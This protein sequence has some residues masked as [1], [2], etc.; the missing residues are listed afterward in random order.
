[1]PKHE[2]RAR[3]CLREIEKI[4]HKYKLTLGAGD[5]IIMELK[6]EQSGSD[7]RLPD[8]IAYTR[9][10]TTPSIMLPRGD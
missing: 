8:S 2:R 6:G 10:D 5:W 4:L 3:R 7:S 9:N 1:M